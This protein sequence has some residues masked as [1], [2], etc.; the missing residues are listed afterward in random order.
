LPIPW[1]EIHESMPAAL[2]LPNVLSRV[3]HL[4]PLQNATVSYSLQGRRRG[5]HTVGPLTAAVGDVFGLVRREMQLAGLQSLL[6][7]PRILSSDELEL[8]AVALFGVVR[9]RRQLLGDPSR[10]AGVR[11]YL[12]G[13]PLHDIHWPATAN[14]G[15]L[16]VKQY[17][18]ATTHQTVIFLDLDSTG[19]NAPDVFSAAEFAI[20]VAATI[21]SRL[22]EQRQEVGLVTNGQVLLAL[23]EDRGPEDESG[24]SP[25]PLAPAGSAKDAAGQG[26]SPVGRAPAPIGPARGRAHLMRILEVLARV[27]LIEHGEPLIGLLSQRTLALPWGTTVVI[28]AGRTSDELFPALHKLRQVGLLVVLFLIEPNPDRAAVEARARAIGAALHVVWRE[29]D[30]QGVHA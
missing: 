5:F 20:S 26:N 10:L 18:P 7:Y 23:A 16:Q 28:V 15:I 17:Q 21:A 24:D 1:L 22:T 19:Y 11:G 12:P 4:A 6:V 13:D 2:A 8:P 30:M 14:T 9:S 29:A 25:A 27:E 3:L